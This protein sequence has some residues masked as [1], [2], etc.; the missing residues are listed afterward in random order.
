MELVQRAFIARLYAGTGRVAEA[1]PH[2]ERCHEILAN[3]EDW[4]VSAG[5]VAF[6]DG[7]V[8]AARG[9][10]TQEFEVHFGRAVD[11]FGRYGTVWDEAEA[12]HEWGRALL[13]AGEKAR[14]ISKFE[15]ALEI[16]RRIGAGERWLNRVLT[17]KIPAQGILNA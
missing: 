13:S 3:G 6:A 10:S 16:Y 11:V 14:A 15:A 7:V 8:S 5:L 17:D 9:S 1:L 2:L 4:S 12:L